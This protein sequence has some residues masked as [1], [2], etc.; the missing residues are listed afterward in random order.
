M[1]III[2]GASGLVGSHLAS[3]LARDHEVAALTHAALDITD[4]DAVRRTVNAVG[5]QVIFNCAV[6]QVDESEQDPAK[7]KAV[8]ADGPRYLAEAAN[9]IGAEIVQFSTQY[10]FAGTPVGRAPYTIEDDLKPV[11]VYGSTK[12]AGEQAV[13]DTCAQ[14]YIVRTSWVY[15]SGKASF[16]CNAHTEL[17]AGKRVRAIDDIWSS[18]TYVEDL[19]DRCLEIIGRRHYAI[20]QVV[21]AGVCTYHEFALEAGRL[22]GL[23]YEQLDS[24]IEITHEREMKRIAARP[25]YTPLRCLVSEKVGLPPLRDWRNALAVYAEE[26]LE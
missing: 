15:G 3:R 13:R 17:K 7:A 21:N 6:F 1:K 26:E 23:S 4:R 11:N 10:V 2:T 22:V 16:L 14:S 24:L 25:R 18:T 20:Y 19:I 5:P 12:V 8:N 9:E